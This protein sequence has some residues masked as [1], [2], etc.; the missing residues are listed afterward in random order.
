MTRLLTVLAALA[1]FAAPVAVQAAPPVSKMAK[2]RV[3]Y[4]D[5]S[6]GFRH[7]PVTRPA[8]SNGPT[9]SEIAL[10]EIGAQTGAFSVESTQDARIITPEKLNDVDVLIFYTTGELP[11]SAEN[12]AAVQAWVKS[13]KGG[14]VGLHSATDTHWDYQGP[15]ETYTAFINGKFAG[16]PWTQGTPITVQALAGKDPVNTVWPSRFPYAEEIYQYSD[17]DP[18][19][20]R[21]LQA[22]DFTDM[23]LKRPWFV[24]VTWTREIGKGR[25]FQTSLGH[26][27][28]TWN[29]PLYRGQILEAVRWTAHRKPGAAKPNTDEQALWALRSLLAYDDRPKAE[30]ETRVAKLAKADTAWLRDAAVRTAALRPLWP[31]KPDSDRAKFDAAYKAVLTDVVAKSGG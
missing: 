29:D 22:L 7:K 25:L 28:S 5:Q 31:A 16:H 17:Y 14:F 2:I 15:G 26:T 1:A 19:K 24:P 23:A 9:Q 6:V 27:P 8:N 13:G 20:V 30:V 4:L 21:A 12:W 10:A 3:L 11:I 18:T